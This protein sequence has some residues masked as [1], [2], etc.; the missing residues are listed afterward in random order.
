LVLHKAADHHTHLQLSGVVHCSSH[1]W[2]LRQWQPIRR[3]STSAASSS[4]SSRRL[5]L[6][7]SLCSLLLLLLLIFILCV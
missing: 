2:K 3:A 6:P 7:R 5:L 4:S 1:L